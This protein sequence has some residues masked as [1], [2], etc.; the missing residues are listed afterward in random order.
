MKL[1]VPAYLAAVCATVALSGCV[2]APVGYEPG[3]GVAYAP[4]PGVV[5]FA[6][7]YAIPGPGYAWRHHGRYGW[8]WQHPRRGWHHGWR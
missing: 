5:Y 2:V 4:P 1:S 7:T 3:Y 8:G 6:P